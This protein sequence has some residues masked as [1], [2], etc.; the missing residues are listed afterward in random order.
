MKPRQPFDR[1][2]KTVPIPAVCCKMGECLINSSHGEVFFYHET[3]VRLWKE[4]V[5]YL[6]PSP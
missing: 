6:H 1:L 3:E 5:S 2:S 4:N